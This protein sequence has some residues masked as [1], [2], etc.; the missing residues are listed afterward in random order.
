MTGQVSTIGDDCLL[1]ETNCV[2]CLHL[3]MTAYFRAQLSTFGYDVKLGNI[4]SPLI[5]ILPTFGGNFQLPTFGCL[6]LGDSLLLDF[7]LAFR[8]LLAFFSQ[9]NI[10]DQCR[11]PRAQPKNSAMPKNCRCRADADM[12]SASTASDSSI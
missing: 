2:Q 11:R 8:L 3:G 6:L 4:F 5:R 9:K 1:S 10:R 7:F 12:L